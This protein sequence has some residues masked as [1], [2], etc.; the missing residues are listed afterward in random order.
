MA[1][2]NPEN[3]D[4]AAWFADFAMQYADVMRERRRRVKA[5]GGGSTSVDGEGE[6]EGAE[7][8]EEEDERHHY[9]GARFV[10][11]GFGALPDSPPSGPRALAALEARHAVADLWL[12]LSLRF[13]HAYCEREAVRVRQ[14]Q[15]DLSAL[16]ERGLALMTDRDGKLGK[17][18]KKKPPGKV[19]QLSARK[20]RRSRT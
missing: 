19:R 8:E 4:E 12:W 14:D 1:P 15:R 5:T 2:V 17:R 16:L 20:Q 6:G 10:R 18:S 13:K 7:D 11:L 9:S 3:A